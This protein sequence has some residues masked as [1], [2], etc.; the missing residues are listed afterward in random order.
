MINK[1][2]ALFLALAGTLAAQNTAQAEDRWS[3]IYKSQEEQIELR[4]QGAGYAG[5]LSANGIS[6]ALTARLQGTSLEGTIAVGPTNVAFKASLVGSRMSIVMDDAS[7]TLEKQ[8]TPAPA[9]PSATSRASGIVGEWRSSTG[10]I[11]FGA[12]GT[13]VNNGN[14]GRYAI[15]DNILVLTAPDG[16]VQIPF[17]LSGDTLTLTVN[18]QAI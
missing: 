1:E 16:S 17:A 14:S 2:T 3:G 15:Q 7:Y 13:V 10:T 9:K 5:T 18:G 12:D 8:E 4:R 11:R 6:L